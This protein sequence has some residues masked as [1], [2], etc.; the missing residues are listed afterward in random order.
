MQWH[1]MSGSVCDVVVGRGILEFEEALGP[2]RFYFAGEEGAE[3][4]LRG[5]VAGMYRELDPLDVTVRYSAE[6]PNESTR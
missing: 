1:K 2:E 3:L 4:V 5:S 6:A